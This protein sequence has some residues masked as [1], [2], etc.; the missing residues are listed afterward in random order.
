MIKLR[1]YHDPI[2]RRRHDRFYRDRRLKFKMATA[3]LSLVQPSESTAWCRM[4]SAGARGAL[5]PPRRPSPAP[6]PFLQPWPCQSL[7]VRSWI[8]PAVLARLRTI[9]RLKL[10]CKWLSLRLFHDKS[11]IITEVIAENNLHTNYKLLF[12]FE[13]RPIFIAIVLKILFHL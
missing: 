12:V 3:Y 7:A 13:L 5:S 10:S 6:Q 2:K 8:A 9:Y 4:I 1:Q 11:R